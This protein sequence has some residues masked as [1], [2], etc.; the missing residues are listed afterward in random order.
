MEFS[1]YGGMDTMFSIIPVI[2]ILVF[3]FV[4]GAIIVSAIRGVSQWQKNNE[5]P[6]LTVE[7]TVVAKRADVSTHHHNVR[8]DNMSHVSSSTI[9]YV[10]FQVASGDRMEFK[11][12]DKEYGIL[13]ESDVGRLTFQGT[14]YLG[15]ER[16]RNY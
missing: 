13:V 12:R 6:V 15:F 3:V 10:T 2:V 9:Y 8:T 4:I 1:S 11:V 5:A 14:R 7:A 16:I